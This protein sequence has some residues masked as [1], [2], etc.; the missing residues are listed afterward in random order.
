MAKEEDNVFPVKLVNKRVLCEML[1]VSPRQLDHLR[2]HEGM[3]WIRLGARVL[4]DP[5]KIAKWIESKTE[6]GEKEN[7]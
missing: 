4:F 1:A 7:V 6:N 2:K 5:V 3:P